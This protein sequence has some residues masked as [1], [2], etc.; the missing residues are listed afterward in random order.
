MC[1]APV[2][3]GALSSK[4][5]ESQQHFFST[6]N[7]SNILLFLKYVWPYFR[8][9]NKMVAATVQL[10]IGSVIRIVG[11]TQYSVGLHLLFKIINLLFSVTL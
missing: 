2:A 7:F 4:Q 6:R 9:I 11:Y 5:H 3:K 10:K 1:S 8:K